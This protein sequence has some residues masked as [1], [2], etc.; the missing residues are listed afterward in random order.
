MRVSALKAMLGAENV[1]PGPDGGFAPRS[2]VVGTIEGTIAELTA[3]QEPEA[4]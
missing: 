4:G 2:E 3:A 1:R